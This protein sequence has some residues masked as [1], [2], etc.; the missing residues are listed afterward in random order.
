MFA[1]SRR[2]SRYHTADAIRGHRKG[3]HSFSIAPAGVSAVAWGALASAILTTKGCVTLQGPYPYEF[4]ASTCQ[5]TRPTSRSWSRVFEHVP[6]P[7]LHAA[8]V[9]VTHVSVV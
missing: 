2:H 5:F 1:P 8:A 9:G 4:Q 3:S 6:L 7:R